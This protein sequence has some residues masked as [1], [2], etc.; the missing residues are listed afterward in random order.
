[1][2]PKQIWRLG[3]FIDDEAI[4][5]LDYI[6]VGTPGT[7]AS[8]MSSNHHNK[9]QIYG[10]DCREIGKHIVVALN[11]LNEPAAQPRDDND[12]EIIRNLMQSRMMGSMARAGIFHILNLDSVSID[13]DKA[14]DAASR[15]QLDAIVE[16][17]KHFV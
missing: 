5:E 2:I 8:M 1:M 14:L 6:W 17:C 10:K 3:N 4:Q 16:K 7:A 11:A 12:R 13:F 15:R 9:I